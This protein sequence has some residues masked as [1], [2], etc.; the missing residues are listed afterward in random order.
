MSADTFRQFQTM[1]RSDPGRGKEPA[2]ARPA[3]LDSEDGFASFAQ[4]GLSIRD[5]L[6]AHAPSEPQPWFTPVMPERPKAPPTPEGHDRQKMIDITDYL[7]LGEATDDELRHAGDP[8]IVRV[9]AA[10]MSAFATAAVAWD[11]EQLR[12]KYAQWPWAWADAVLAARDLHANTQPDEVAPADPFG[13]PRDDPVVHQFVAEFFSRGHKFGFDYNDLRLEWSTFVGLTAEVGR[14]LARVVEDTNERGR[15]IHDWYGALD[16][17]AEVLLKRF[18]LVVSE[19]GDH[20]NIDPDAFLPTFE[21]I[22]D[23]HSSKAE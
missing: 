14:E 3:T 4:P 12:Q 21:A 23:R 9:F 8:A 7:D 20:G 5:Y 1:M 17:A 22:L 19:G 16:E 15:E 13:V 10:E 2:F 11:R 6:A 18:R